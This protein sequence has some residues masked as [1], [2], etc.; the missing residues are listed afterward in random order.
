MTSR[1]A[2]AHASPARELSPQQNTPLLSPLDAHPANLLTHA[3]SVWDAKFWLKPHLLMLAIIGLLLIVLWLF[4]LLFH[5]AGSL[6]HLVLVLAVIL[7][8]FHLLFGRKSV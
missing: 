6:I 3:S 7:F 2:A 8:I 5:I 1:Q 4:G